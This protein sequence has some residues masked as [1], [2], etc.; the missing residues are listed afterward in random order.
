MTLCGGATRG[1]LATVTGG[2]ATPPRGFVSG[3]APLA[4]LVGTETGGVATVA[5]GGAGAFVA[6]DGGA[7]TD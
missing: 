4:A 3:S 6:T 2:V 5:W 1:A 7:V